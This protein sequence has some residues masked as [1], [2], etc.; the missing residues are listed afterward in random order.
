MKTKKLLEKL[1]EFEQLLRE[2]ERQRESLLGV[3]GA[4][5]ASVEDL[6]IQREQVSYSLDDFRLTLLRTYHFLRP[7]IET[8]SQC[9]TFTSEGGGKPQEIYEVLIERGTTR[10]EP[11]YDDLGRI[12]DKLSECDPE[13]ELDHKGNPIEE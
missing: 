10:F 1:D 4:N 7:F 13:A 9:F 12:R 5:S 11:I 2:F 6:P 3:S 8:Y